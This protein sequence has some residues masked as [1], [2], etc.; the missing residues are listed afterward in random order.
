MYKYGPNQ[1]KKETFEVVFWGL[2]VERFQEVADYEVTELAKQ[3]DWALAISMALLSALILKGGV[4]GSEKWF[5]G[6]LVVSIGFG[7]A[8]KL[9]SP[10]YRFSKPTDTTVRS[11]LNEMNSPTLQEG[12]FKDMDFQERRFTSFNVGVTFS[13]A[14]KPGGEKVPK[15]VLEGE[16]ES[17]FRL[18]AF[19]RVLQWKKRLHG[20]QL[21]LAFLAI[22]GFCMCLLIGC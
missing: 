17:V 6:A 19:L 8:A 12:F 9:W 22:L 11:R 21:V 1:T 16:D 20:V 10:R 2:L 5:L 15:E 18:K 7:I 14:V 4:P 13:H 3:I